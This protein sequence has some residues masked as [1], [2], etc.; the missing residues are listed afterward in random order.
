MCNEQ[1]SGLKNKG[2]RKEVIAKMLRIAITSEIK[3]AHRKQSGVWGF[4]L[5][6]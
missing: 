4:N 5:L 1:K 3:E 6:D 2:Q